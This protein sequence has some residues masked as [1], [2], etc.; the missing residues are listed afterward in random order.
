MENIDCSY[1]GIVDKIQGDN[2]KG[3][4]FLIELSTAI[5]AG[6]DKI[7][8]VKKQLKELETN[9]KTLRAGIDNVIKH[10]KLKSNLTIMDGDSMIIIT[11]DFVT[12]Y[13]K[14]L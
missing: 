5:I 4:E 2:D 14:D 6:E 8:A 9:Q 1:S 7:D 3:K 12:K 10:L 11:D 13:K